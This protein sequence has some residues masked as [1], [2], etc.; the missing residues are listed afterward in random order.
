MVYKI[1]TVMY[2]IPVTYPKPSP[3]PSF[4]YLI[5]QGY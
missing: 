3:I 1:E 2:I 5:Y 4:L